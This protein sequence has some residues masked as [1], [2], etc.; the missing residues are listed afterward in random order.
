MTFS[1]YLQ[2]D[3]RFPDRKLGN[4]T[5]GGPGFLFCERHRERYRDTAACPVCVPNQTPPPR[6]RVRR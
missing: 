3:K 5:Y 1:R 4:T 6:R 2:R